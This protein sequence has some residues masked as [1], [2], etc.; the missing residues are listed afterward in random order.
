MRILTWNVNGLR[1]VARKGFLNWLEE[2]DPDILCV[3]EIKAMPE[4]VD[5]GLRDLPG[6]HSIWNPA[7]RKGYS[8]T[9]IYTKEKPAITA[10]GIGIERFDTEG[11]IIQA[12]Y[13]DFVLLNV[14]F[15]NGRAREER[16]QYKLEFYDA[17][18]EHIDALVQSGRDVIFCGDVNTAHNEIDLAHPKR[19]SKISGF[20]RVERDWLDKVLQ[21]G[22]VDTFRHFHPDTVKYTWWDYRNAARERDV[23]W[24][25][26]YFMVNSALLPRVKEAFIMSE[27][28]GS[29]HCPVGVELMF[30]H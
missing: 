17:F 30:Q 15:P 7:A 4:Q 19:N 8:G 2:E 5:E 1:A 10:K 20:L 21:H 27:V 29:D 13:G 24:R 6:Y 9:L 28:M 11:R 22:W 23:G 3:Q 26:D 16:L 25:L 18:L 12:D 14:Y